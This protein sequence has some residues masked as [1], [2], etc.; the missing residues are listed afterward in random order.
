MP[1]S[2]SIPIEERR[3]RQ[4]EANRRFE[5]TNPEAA[6]AIR[7]RFNQKN[8]EEHAHYQVEWRRR[9]KETDPAGFA[10]YKKRTSRRERARR[11]RGQREAIE[12]YG[13]KCYCCGEQTLIFLALDHIHGGG[14]QHRKMLGSDRPAAWAKRNGWP[15]IFRVACHNCNFGAYLNEGF[16]PHLFDKV[17]AILQLANDWLTT[18]KVVN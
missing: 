17:V 18:N 16:C 7:R 6:K 9:L 15:P 11:Q 14:S 4:I 8:R 3:R 10:E 13:G 12:H 5:G 2:K 1:Y